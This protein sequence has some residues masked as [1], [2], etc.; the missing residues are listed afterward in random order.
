MVILIPINGVIVSR[1][2]KLQ[3]GIMKSKDARVRA[4][5]ELLHGIKVIKFFAW[6]FSFQR[7]ITTIRDEELLNL[8]KTAILSSFV[9]FMWMST[10]LFVS[11]VTFITYTLAGN[12]L[13]ATTAFT[14][15]SLFNI[16]RFPLNIL[17]SII[18]QVVQASVSLKRLSKYLLSDEVDPNVVS[19]HR[20][21]GDVAVS[22]SNGE[23]AWSSE[24]GI[25]ATLRDIN[26][27]VAYGELVAVVGSVGS[28]KSSLLSAILGDIRKKSGKVDLYGTVAFVAQEA[29]IQNATLR[30]NILFGLP[31]NEERYNTAV[32]VCELEQDLNILPNRDLTEIGEKGINLSGG[33]KQRVSMA[34]AV[35]ANADIYLLDDPLSAV[36]AHVGKNI[37]N[38]C[39]CKALQGKTRILVTHQLQHLH[40]VDTIIVMKNGVFSEKGSYDELM[41]NG[42]EFSELINTHVNIQEEEEKELEEEKEEQS[43]DPKE[44]KSGGIIQQEERTIGEVS[45]NVYWLYIKSLG[46][47]TIVTVLLSFFF[48]EQFSKVSADW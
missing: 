29:W 12:E 21:K 6:E 43:K 2:K 33:Q 24:E 47:V 25:P 16:L 18:T 1:L 3:L 26:M 34:R 17:P 4:M 11:I 46:G 22:I 19:R 35:Y 42:H 41:E 37:F 13:L 8:R 5:N 38:E 32:K 31:W 48:L 44:K 23:F 40:N 7:R 28:G 45:A 20:E 36:D 27:K 14:S 10:P 30:D 15:L 9:T 39:I